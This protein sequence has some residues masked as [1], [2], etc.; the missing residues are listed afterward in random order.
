MPP[1]TASLQHTIVRTRYAE[2]TARLLSEVAGLRIGK[3]WHNF[4]PLSTSNSVALDLLQV[5]SPS[6]AA[7]SPPSIA[8]QHCAFF[9]D[10]SGFEAGLRALKSRKIEF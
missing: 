6:T 7:S 3:I 9:N 1:P 8:P 10:D 5:E 4:L 2:A